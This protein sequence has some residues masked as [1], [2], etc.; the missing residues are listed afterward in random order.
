MS[1][2]RFCHHLY[3]YQ[4]LWPFER[5]DNKITIQSH[6]TTV[7]LQINWCNCQQLVSL[8]YIQGALQW[9]ETNQDYHIWCNILH[10]RIIS[11]NSLQ[12]PSI[13]NN[14]TNSGADGTS[15]IL[16]GWDWTTKCAVRTSDVRNSSSLVSYWRVIMNTAYMGHAMYEMESTFKCM[17]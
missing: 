17:Q 14:P 5:L 4:N 10:P 1:W 15:F 7:V 3:I 9:N 6:N 2:L 11:P 16:I 13:H 8:E 12:S